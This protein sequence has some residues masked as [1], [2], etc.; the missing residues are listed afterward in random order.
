MAVDQPSYPLF[1]YD[2]DCGI[3]SSCARWAQRW[4]PSPAPLVPWQRTDLEAL[5][6]TLAEVEE[7][8]VWVTSPRHHTAGPEAIADLLGASRPWWRPVGWL[9]ATRPVLWVA[10]PVYRWIAEH[11]SSLPGGTPTCAL[12]QDERDRGTDTGS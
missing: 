4:V 10:W 2:G 8:V 9:L 5:G 12:P 7:A 1:L 6:V 11:R 3:C